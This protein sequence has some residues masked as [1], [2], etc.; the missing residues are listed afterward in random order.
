MK[1]LI[2]NKLIYN[3]ESGELIR[4]DIGVTDKHQLTKTA[5]HIL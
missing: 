5:N 1:Y 3:A 2:E 4:I